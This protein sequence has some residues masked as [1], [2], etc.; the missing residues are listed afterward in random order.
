M[1][2]VQK[3][4]WANTCVQQNSWAKC[5]TLQ[6]RNQD[7]FLRWDKAYVVGKNWP[8]LSFN[9]FGNCCLTGLHCCYSPAFALT[10]AKIFRPSKILTCVRISLSYLAIDL[11][12]H[13]LNF[14]IIWIRNKLDNLLDC[15]DHNTYI[16]FFKYF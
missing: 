13:L 15:F 11:A 1:V 16:F 12:K 9:V 5:D 10:L 8:W 3:T 6:G 7:F 4:D 2:V 14:A